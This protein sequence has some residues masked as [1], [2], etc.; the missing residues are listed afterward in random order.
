MNFFI[1]FQLKFSFRALFIF[2]L[3]ETLI[4]ISSISIGLIMFAKYYNCDPFS[5]GAVKE[6]DQL[7]PHFI[8]DVAGHIQGLPGLFIAGIF[9]AALRFI[10][11][12]EI[13]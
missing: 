9:C 2:L 3:G 10:N 5:I 8:M 7:L 4:K 1:Y 13:I 11:S 12:E 6:H